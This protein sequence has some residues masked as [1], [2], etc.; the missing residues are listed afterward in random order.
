MILFDENLYNLQ[1][2]TARKKHLEAMKNSLYDQK[3]ELDKNMFSLKYAK[4]KEQEDVDKLNKPSLSN[5]FYRLT[6]KLEDKLTAEQKEA[7]EAAIKYD[8][9][10]QELEAIELKIKQIQEEL[11]TL[12]NVE[13]EYHDTLNAKKNQIKETNDP[14]KE[15]LLKLEKSLTTAQAQEKEIRE[16][17][18]AGNRCL[19]AANNV[20][21]NLKKASDWGTW[22]VIGGGTMST[23]IKHDYMSKAQSSV[24]AL[25]SELRYF[26]SELADVKIYSNMNV[27]TDSF[28]KFADFFFDNIFIDLSVQDR[29]RSSL[30]SVSGTKNQIQSALSK[31]NRLMDENRKKQDEIKNHI[32]NYLIGQQIEL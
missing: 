29:I 3:R 4:R 32:E 5:F 24:S 12:N 20:I 13:R 1:Q 19:Y 23:L 17:M 8:A 28:T 18:A 10:L 6:G 31:L 9:A 22:D 11:D 21:D 27:S 7:C 30:N 15:E 25:Q 2:K 16:A 14:E 26:K